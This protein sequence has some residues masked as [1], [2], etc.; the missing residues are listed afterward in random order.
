[1]D[2]PIHWVQIDLLRRE[3]H[4]ALPERDRPTQYLVRVLEKV[5]QPQ[6]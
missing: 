3:M 4:G 6:G 1:M 5:Q 2:S